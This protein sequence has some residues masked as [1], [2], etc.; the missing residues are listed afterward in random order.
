MEPATAFKSM[1]EIACDGR[2][3]NSTTK[4]S[5]KRVGFDISL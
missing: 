5:A 4:D 2:D 1:L 3:A